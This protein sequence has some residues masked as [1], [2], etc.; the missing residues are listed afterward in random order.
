MLIL[1]SLNEMSFSFFYLIPCRLTLSDP[2]QKFMVSDGFYRAVQSNCSVTRCA[3][4]DGTTSYPLQTNHEESDT[5]IFLHVADTECSTVHIRS[6]DRD[7][8]MVGLPLMCLFGQKQL[9]IEFKCSPNLA[10][11]HMNLLQKAIIDDIQLSCIPERNR[12]EAIQ[13]VYIV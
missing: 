6:L 9:Y 8:A 10:F 11:L 4:I 1:N 13:T 2:S 7:I 3:T 12:C 5:Q